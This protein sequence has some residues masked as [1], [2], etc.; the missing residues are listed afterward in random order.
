MVK[1]SDGGFRDTAIHTDAVCGLVDFLKH[2]SPGEGGLRSACRRGLP[3]RYCHSRAF[4]M[5]RDFL[6]YVSEQQSTAPGPR[7][8]D[9]PQC[10]QRQLELQFPDED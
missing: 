9:T 6:Q 8:G 2:T 1:E 7:E 3:V 4:I 5:G 10:V